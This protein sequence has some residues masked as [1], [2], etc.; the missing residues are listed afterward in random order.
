MT[1]ERMSIQN[2]W[3]GT[4]LGEGGGED[5]ELPVSL[6]VPQDPTWTRPGLKSIVR[7]QTPATDPLSHSKAVLFTVK[8]TLKFI[9]K[10]PVLPK[11]KLLVRRQATYR[12]LNARVAQLKIFAIW[13]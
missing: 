1:E 11:N 12:S 3:S 13:S 5:A 6:R 9:K 8:I 10:N 2:W 7:R 4:D